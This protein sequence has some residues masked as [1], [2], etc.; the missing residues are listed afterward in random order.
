M[1][2]KILPLIIATTILSSGLIG[3]S[4]A[5][6]NQDTVKKV[7]A[8]PLTKSS[9]LREY[10]PETTLLYARIP[11]LLT[12]I[13]SKDDSFKNALGN[14]QYVSAINNIKKASKQW[15][16]KSDKD[17]QP[18]LTLLMA[19]LDGPTELVALMNGPLPS[20]LVT[21]SLDITSSDE[22]QLLIDSLIK[23]KI[24]RAEKTKLTDNAGELITEL[25]AT[26]YRWDPKQK[27][28]NILLS[29]GGTNIAELDKTFSA[30][31]KND[32]S[33]MLANEAKMESS[34]QGL[35]VW[36]NNEAAYP[37]AQAMAP[38]HIKQ[39]LK[40]LGVQDMKSLALSWGVTNQKGR[41]KLLLEAPHKGLVRELLPINSNA[42]DIATAGEPN[43]SALIALPSAEDFSS[44]E[45][46][47][48]ALS[49]N[50]EKYL[51][52]KAGFAEKM[53]FKVEDVFASVGPELAVISDKSGEYSAIRI[54]DKAKFSL[55]LDALKSK[56]AVE[57]I[58][59]EV[60]AKPITYMKI[61]AFIDQEMT[62]G[63]KDVPFFVTDLLT[64]ANSHVFW[65]QE[66]DYLIVSDLPQVLVDRNLLLAQQDQQKSLSTWLDN[67][68]KQDLSTSLLAL[69]GSIDNAPR[70]L[71]YTYINVIQLLAD[72]TDAEVD[73]FSLPSARQLTLA[74]SGT[75]GIQLDSAVDSLGMEITFESTPADIILTTQG[76]ASVATVGTLAAVAIPAYQD[77]LFK[78]S[79]ASANF[80]ISMAKIKIEELFDTQSRLPNAQE[81]EEITLSQRFSS[82]YD[83]SVQ[84][85]TGA[86]NVTITSKPGKSML[87]EPIISQGK[88]DWQCRTD[89][90]LQ[91]RPKNCT[92]DM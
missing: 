40:V 34:K 19:Q 13:S 82:K 28:L 67:T 60:D 84:A 92:A 22:L 6:A 75:L 90:N 52:A 66:G 62:D 74:D 14:Q 10:L 25:G 27:R 18:L 3:I 42:L 64:K 17:I 69:S 39:Q 35:Y 38:A 89:L 5:Q 88:I 72:I 47:I 9:W 65:Q 20:V 30:L 81:A 56:L 71:Y 31:V 85:D 70:R 77:Y 57:I 63:L 80:D 86:I 43:F 49:P 59:K 41:I 2:R 1:K 11:S 4:T 15:L 73:I 36:L 46:K 33:T 83:L 58:T 51:Q 32:S 48:L 7:D 8:V 61:P 79:I 54:R 26:P 55:I 91:D 23:A 24:I 16:T 29:V 45:S 21:T 87:V 50:S 37:L 53:G 76:I 78:A 12:S 68:Q 44:I